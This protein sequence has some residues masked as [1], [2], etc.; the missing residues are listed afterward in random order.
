MVTPPPVFSP[1]FTQPLTFDVEARVRDL[2]GLLLDKSYEHQKENILHAI[3]LYE[4]GKLPRRGVVN[5]WFVNGKAISYPFQPTEG[6]TIWV[7]V[8]HISL[9]Y[10]NALLTCSIEYRSHA[11][12]AGCSDAIGSVQ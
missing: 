8:G 2:R 1:A 5:T 9:F 6:M 12:Y 10:V 4:T 11:A 7:E 3:H